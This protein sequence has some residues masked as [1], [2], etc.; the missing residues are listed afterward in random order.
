MKRK[1]FTW[2]AIVTNVSLQ[3]NAGIME[4]IYG[5]GLL[6]F[7]A[8]NILQLPP[9]SY[10]IGGFI[11]LLS[12]YLL[13]ALSVQPIAKRN[14]DIV[15]CNVKENMIVIAFLFL[16]IIGGLYLLKFAIARP[17]VNLKQILYMIG[18]FI[19]MGIMAISVA[20]GIDRLMI[21]GQIIVLVTILFISSEVS[22]DN[23]LCFISAI[24]TL[25]AGVGIV[26]FR[27]FTTK[28]PL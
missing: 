18:L 22:V 15:V 19:S 26:N 8:I 25:I 16:A 1:A 4:I 9:I 20:N 2:T 5:L 14:P 7:A 28:Y 17:D 13:N 10:I 11:V 12:F 27:R 21:Y 24:G 23:L 3:T 6:F